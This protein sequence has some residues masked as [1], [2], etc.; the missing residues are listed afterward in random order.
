M[1][2]CPQC[3][4]EYDVTLSYCL[5]D[6]S[7]LLY[8]SGLAPSGDEAA[9][10]ILSGS[11]PSADLR[12]SIGKRGGFVNS[13]AVL[14]FA[15]WS[16]EPDNQHFCD[17]LAEDIINSLT[18]IGDLKVA[19]C[20]SSF[21]FKG[22]DV[23]AAQVGRELGVATI[24]DGSVRR[25]GDRLRV[26]IQLVTAADGVQIWSEQYDRTMGDVFEIQDELTRVVV[27]AIRPILLTQ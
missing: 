6:G 22:K 24:L 12:D 13:I 10:A 7:G 1:K 23:N 20:T 15:D 8:S 18:K 27:E 14:P 4:R 17:G 11:S 16:S 25:L 3:G 26:T 21:Y 19:S 9:T 5:D 2:R